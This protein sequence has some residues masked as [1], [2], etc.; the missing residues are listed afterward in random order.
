M[1]L[2]RHAVT[3]VAALLIASI[4]P[5]IYAQVRIAVVDL[6]R[7]LNE[8]ED[9]RRAKA[10]LKRL[11]KQR[12]QDLDKRQGELKTLKEDIEKN[13]EVWSRDVL[14]KR[15]EEYQKVFVE[16]Q[17]Q[18]VE[19]QRELAEKEAEMTSQI[20]ARMESIL[21][22]IGQAEGYT[23]IVERSEG[24]VVWVPSNLDLTDTVIQRYNAGEG[25]E[26]DA[27]G[28]GGA[29]AAGGGDGGGGAGASTKRTGTGATGGAATGTG[30]ARST[31]K[32]TTTAE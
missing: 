23:M 27:A 20:I 3:L 8:T 17:Q 29:A 32:R 30:G 19:Y 1:Q 25:R 11:F 28:G 4:S 2:Q 21:R 15:V 13:R 24:G 16:L 9:G 22:R 6:Q 18:Y 12:Q 31:T 14:Q 5:R 7:A 26:A 10:R